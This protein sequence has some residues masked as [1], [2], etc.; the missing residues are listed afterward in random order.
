MAAT[1]VDLGSHAVGGAH[2]RH[3]KVTADA[4]TAVLTLGDSPR[5]LGMTF[6]FK[7]TGSV[8][9]LTTTVAEATGA[10]TVSGLTSTD[11]FYVTVIT[12]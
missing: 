4:A 10:I 5:I 11:V 7:T 1:I 2:A 9:A 8:S 3:F 6:P 12:A